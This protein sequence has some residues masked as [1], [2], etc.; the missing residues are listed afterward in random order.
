MATRGQPPHC[1]QPL[2]TGDEQSRE[3]YHFKE[4]DA[5]RLSKFL[6]DEVAHLWEEIAISVGL[7]EAVREECGDSRKFATR[8]YKILHKWITGKYIGTVP[9]TMKE[10]RNAL[11]GPFVQK[12]VL[13]SKL[14]NFT[15]V[16][17]TAV[18]SSDEGSKQSLHMY[19][20]EKR[21]LLVQRY[22]REP[23]VVSDINWPPVVAE[24]FVNLA[25]VKPSDKSYQSD[26]SVS[27]N[28]DEEL[29]TKE[30]IEYSEAFGE[31]VSGSNTL[32]IGRP[33][34]GKTTLFHKIVKD[35]AKGEVLREAELAFL[36]S[37][38]AVNSEQEYADLS[39]ILQPYYKAKEE[40]R[41][42]VKRFEDTKGKKLCLMLDGFDENNC[43]D[44]LV[45]FIHALLDKSY[46]PNAMV[47]MSSR[48]A[49]VHRSIDNKLFLKEIEVFGFSNDKVN[50]YIDSFPF[51][52]TDGL[53][54]K[55]HYTQ[56]KEYLLTHPQVADMCYL[57][58]NL[59]IICFIYDCEPNDIPHTLA[60]IY[61][62]FTRLIVIRHLS[63]R[64]LKM[65]HLKS[66]D[67]LDPD[68]YKNFRKLCSLAFKMTK[69]S[70]VVIREGGVSSDDSLALG[71]A[72]VDIIAYLH[73]FQNSYSFL[74][75]T[76]Q[77]YLAA[78]YIST[79]TTKKQNEIIKEHSSSVHM[80]TVWK[81]Y[82]GLIDFSKG[83]N[84]AK[85]IFDGIDK[86]CLL[87][88]SSWFKNRCAYESRRPDISK[89]I[90][91]ELFTCHLDSYNVA[92][93]AALAYVMSSNAD[94][95]T[96]T[97]SLTLTGS[98]TYKMETLVRG[99][100]NK[101][102]AKLK[103][104][105]LSGDGLVYES[106]LSIAGKLEH[107]KLVK[108][109][110][111]SLNP[112]CANMIVQKIPM[113]NLTELDLSDTKMSSS[114]A[115]TLAKGLENNCQ[116]QTLDLS[117]NF[118]GCI[119]IEALS[120]V[121]KNCPNFWSLDLSNNEI[122]IEDARAL[123]DLI[124]SCI[125]ITFLDLSRNN[126]GAN[127]CECL[128]TIQKSIAS[129]V[130][131]NWQNPVFLHCDYRIIYPVMNGLGPTLYTGN[132]LGAL[133]LSDNAINLECAMELSD[134][135]TEHCQHLHTLNLSRN[136]IGTNGVIKVF[137]N[138]LNHPRLNNL[139]LAYNAED[140]SKNIPSILFTFINLSHNNMN[141]SHIAEL[142]DGIKRYP[143]HC[144]LLHNCRRLRFNNSQDMLSVDFD[145]SFNNINIDDAKC[146]LS[147]LRPSAAMQYI[148]LMNNPIPDDANTAIALKKAFQ[149]PEV[150][151][152]ILLHPTS[153]IGIKFPSEQSESKDTKAQTPR[154]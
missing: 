24:S 6:A 108:L 19:E 84:R 98:G 36:I 120:D 145:I 61:E 99:L 148:G 41:C 135:V 118:I 15:S 97:T 87:Y 25:L 95:S 12:K 107:S 83:I 88:Y 149:H 134:Y 8:L 144:A 20:K 38:R 13:A 105:D 57:P 70:Q 31:F 17:M 96:P 130:H 43:N 67:Y 76:L 147:A 14:E 80:L 110:A 22:Q 122:K 65:A 59:A 26:Y 64:G 47:I 81:F 32:V 52:S 45:S 142:A 91:S 111:T 39:G 18:V 139:N 109:S 121:L 115:V 133:K 146:F 82:F 63:K 4:G 2:A 60:K 124:N 152:Y 21:D 56:L 127:G 150:D 94:H 119:G 71:L 42:L 140:S 33:G 37:L 141:S 49:A 74:H 1:I 143:R 77:E 101:A 79:L 116:L 51:H 138:L 114:E 23:D 72:T 58:V 75:L 16:N 73:G 85:L 46:L 3:D 153:K 50:D 92:D 29:T 27:G 48:P 7:P 128:H 117:N 78:Y 68:N 10:L 103:E 35:W 53:S 112:D 9:A 44:K 102:A 86:C 34:S 69:N 28:A 154:Q 106:V 30:R 93:V 11:A 136:I 113:K 5:L 62:T 132:I 66:L 54:V 89:L 123:G 137:L 129:S 40:L 104:F 125:N 131:P 100:S 55:H 90:S 151:K 126:L